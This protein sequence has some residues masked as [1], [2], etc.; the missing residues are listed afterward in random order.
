VHRSFSL[1]GFEMG[2]DIL[3]LCKDTM[4]TLSIETPGKDFVQTM[5]EKVE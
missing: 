1:L 5:A 2:G 4:M 3:G